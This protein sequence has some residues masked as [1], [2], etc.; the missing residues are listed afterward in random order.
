MLYNL[1]PLMA[2]ALSLVM[3][4]IAAKVMPGGW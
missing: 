2:V 4:V 3:L 1:D